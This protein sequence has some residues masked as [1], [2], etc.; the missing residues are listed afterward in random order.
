MHYVIGTLYILLTTAQ[1]NMVVYTLFL[2][3]EGF[4][5]SL[6]NIEI[7]GNNLAVCTFFRNK[8]VW[9]FSISTEVGKKIRREP[10][11]K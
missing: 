9:I 11:P 6:K 10:Q 1:E 8:N 5:T 7:I 3:K 4:L 2:P